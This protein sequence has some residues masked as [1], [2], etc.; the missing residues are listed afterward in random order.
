VEEEVARAYQDYRLALLSHDRVREDAAYPLLLAHREVA[1][2]LARRELKEAT[3]APDRE[4]AEKTIRFL[5]D[6]P[7]PRRFHRPRSG[8]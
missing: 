2:G 5:S 8:T 4:L 7:G 1:L 6:P 3:C